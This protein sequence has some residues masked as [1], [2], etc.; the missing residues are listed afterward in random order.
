LCRI[1][2]NA[3]AD[4]DGEK[5]KKKKRNVSERRRILRGSVALGP[6]QARMID[7]KR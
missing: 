7:P 5:E 2:T 1:Q 4:R 3:A 6:T